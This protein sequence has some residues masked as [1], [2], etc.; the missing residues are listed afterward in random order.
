MRIHNAHY[1]YIDYFVLFNVKKVLCSYSVWY[2]FYHPDN[3][4]IHE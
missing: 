1:L 3:S 4:L 2:Y